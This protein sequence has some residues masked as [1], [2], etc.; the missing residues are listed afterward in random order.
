MKDIFKNRHI[1]IQ[2]AIVL[3]AVLF[4]ARLFYIQ[5]IDSRYVSMARS[6]AIKEVDVYPTRGLVYDR[7]GELI[8]YNEA[9]YDLM[10][11]PR[12]AKGVDSAKL[13][14]LLG[15]PLSR[16]T[17]RWAEVKD[18]RK[19]RGYSQYKPQV[20]WKQVSQQDYSRLPPSSFSYTFSIPLLPT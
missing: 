17:E 6:N 19:N 15:I 20:F 9:I 8:V 4:I 11:V 1:V 16:Y 5:V 10:V 7:E 18:T 3:V 14:E 2:I 13:C 12:Q